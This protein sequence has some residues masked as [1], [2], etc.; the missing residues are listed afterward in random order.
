MGMTLE[1]DPGRG[2]GMNR[3]GVRP[4]LAVAI[5]RWGAAVRKNECRCVSEVTEK[6]QV[7]HAA[8]VGKFQ[9]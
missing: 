2:D 8:V 1:N 9:G 7:T 5:V 3:G 6:F 4:L